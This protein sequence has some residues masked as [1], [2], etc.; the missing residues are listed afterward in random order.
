ME[1]FALGKTRTESTPNDDDPGGT[2]STLGDGNLWWRTS[3]LWRIWRA[4]KVWSRLR[5]SRAG[6]PDPF[7]LRYVTLLL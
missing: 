3:N 1:T 2:A 7:R 4:N 5:V 6:S